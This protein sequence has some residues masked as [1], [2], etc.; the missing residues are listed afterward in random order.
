PDAL[1]RRCA[2]D[3]LGQHPGVANVKWLLDLQADPADSHLLYVRK[4]ALRNQLVP[5][6][7]LAKLSETKLSDA[8]VIAIADACVG[9]ATADAGNFLLAHVG[10]IAKDKDRL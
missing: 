1:V 7:N 10:E 9:V 5:A 6:G 8:D 2:A 3:A 4:M